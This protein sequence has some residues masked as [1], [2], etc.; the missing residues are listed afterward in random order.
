MS[1]LLSKCKQQRRNKK[2]RNRTEREKQNDR[3]LPKKEDKQHVI[4]E[5]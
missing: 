4:I 1:G 3:K 2:C 5:Q